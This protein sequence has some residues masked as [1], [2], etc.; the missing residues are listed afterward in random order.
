LESPGVEKCENTRRIKYEPVEDVGNDVLISGEDVSDTTNDEFNNVSDDDDEEESETD[1]DGF[2]ILIAESLP[3]FGTSG[4]VAH[5]VELFQNQSFICG[6]PQGVQ[7]QPTRSYL[8]KRNSDTSIFAVRETISYITS[9]FAILRPLLSFNQLETC[10]GI[11][12]RLSIA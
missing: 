8:P 9:A 1:D 7:L 12:Y 3:T 4:L 10:E 6:S 5:C 11:S 2:P